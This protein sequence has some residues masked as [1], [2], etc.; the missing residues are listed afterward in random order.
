[1]ALLYSSH[2]V[3]DAN[4]FV[5]VYLQ[6]Q[7]VRDKFACIDNEILRSP[8]D[9]NSIA[10]IQCFNSLDDAIGLRNDPDFLLRMQMAGVVGACACGPNCSCGPDCSCVSGDSSDASECKCG[11][12]KEGDTSI[13]LFTKAQSCSNITEKERSMLLI[14]QET[15]DYNK[16]NQ[17]YNK[18]IDLFKKYHVISR[19]VYTLPADTSKILV[20][21][22]FSNLKDCIEMSEDQDLFVRMQQ[23]CKMESSF[24]K[25]V[26]FEIIN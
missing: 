16:W 2:R 3:E 6:G 7:Y 4:K 26:V 19:H 8:E 20:V 15:E 21:H 18:S 13:M 5:A 11:C 24:A 25:K 12:S 9:P 22:T 17:V 14:F 10:T 23:C 1:M